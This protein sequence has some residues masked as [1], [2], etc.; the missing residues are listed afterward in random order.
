MTNMMLAS[1]TIYLKFCHLFKDIEYVM[2]S[3]SSS[4]FLQLFYKVCVIDIHS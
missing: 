3:A 4:S 2:E 1:K